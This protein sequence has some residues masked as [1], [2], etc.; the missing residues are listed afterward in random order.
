MSGL[1]NFLDKSPSW[2]LKIFKLPLFHLGNFQI[3]KNAFGQ[4]IPNDL[5]KHV[6]T[7]TNFE[8]YDGNFRKQTIVIQILLNISISKRNQ[9]MKCRQLIEHNM[10]NIF[11]EKL[12]K[13]NSFLK[14]Q[15]WLYLW[16]SN[17]RFYTVC[18]Y[19]MPSRGLSKY[20]ETKLHTTCFFLI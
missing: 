10:R 8:I 5:P 13:K 14:N 4:F 19:C 17:L 11:L 2:F 9:A 20:I 7:G 6:I 1:G 16:I 18:F 15:S 12:F 3:F